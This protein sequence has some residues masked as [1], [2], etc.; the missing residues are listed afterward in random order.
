MCYKI[1]DIKEK[2]YFHLPMSKPALGHKIRVFFHFFNWQLNPQPYKERTLTFGSLKLWKHFSKLH[3]IY[4]ELKTPQPVA[5][6]LTSK[7]NRSFT[8]TTS[9]YPLPCKMSII[10]F[11]NWHLNPQPCQ[12]KVRALTLGHLKL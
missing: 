7:K 5:I 3:K 10:N 1:A 2:L 8:S 11:S 9:N 12:Y 4:Q 6:L